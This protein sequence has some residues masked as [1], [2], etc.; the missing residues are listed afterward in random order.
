MPDDVQPTEGQGTDGDGGIF[1]PYLE[2]VPEE[3]RETVTGYL[4]D[5]EKNVNERLAEASELKKTWEPYK[6]VEALT[7][8]QPEALNELLAWHQ[9]VTSSDE[10]FQDW[11][12]QAAG[13]AGFTKAETEQLEDAESEGVLS[14]AKIEELV[15][16]RA[17]QQVQP[18]EQRFDQWEQQQQINATETEI[19]DELTALEKE[20]S[21]SLS[22]EQKAMVLDLGI[23]HEGDGNWVRSGFER[24]Q[25]ITSEGQRAFVAEKSGQ[26]ATAL[27]AGAAEMLKPATSFD[28]A[29]KQLR[30]RLRQNS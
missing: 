4:K 21:I 1:A 14:Q 27:S 16:E 2:A 30:E 22:D 23:N 10:A 12:A 9:Q 6:Q 29:G 17:A 3:H 18:L 26:P 20:H 24:F 15:A 13:E 25:Q 28:E 7:Q 11:L 19:R 5:A 8:Y